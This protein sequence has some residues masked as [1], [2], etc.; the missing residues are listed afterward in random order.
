M[1]PPVEGCATSLRHQ[2]QLPP[3]FGRIVSITGFATK[4][5]ADNAGPSTLE[6][7]MKGGS[8]QGVARRSPRGIGAGGENR[9]E[10]CARRQLLATSR[11]Q[12][13][14]AQ[15]GPQLQCP[16]PLCQR[17]LVCEAQAPLSLL[18]GFWH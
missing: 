7:A 2:H 8:F 13:R 1:Q 15:R 14:Q 9:R 10:Q 5:P 3:P 18:G 6:G 4:P 16:A 12:L 11:E 17:R